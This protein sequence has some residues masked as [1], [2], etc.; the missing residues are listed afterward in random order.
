[1]T[2]ARQHYIHS[3]EEGT[4]C[5]I[6]DE[7]FEGFYTFPDEDKLVLEEVCPS[8]VILHLLEPSLTLTNEDMENQ[9]YQWEVNEW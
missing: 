8:C 2:Q 1:M 5:G 7:G 4:R 9:A 3:K 6:P